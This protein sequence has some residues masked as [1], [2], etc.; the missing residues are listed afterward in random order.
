MDETVRNMLVA[1]R[2]FVRFKTARL[3][4]V[5]VEVRVEAA[6]PR[7]D[8][9]SYDHVAEASVGFPSGR[10]FVAGRTDWVGGSHISVEPGTYRVRMLCSVLD[11]LSG[12]GVA[13]HDAYA[14][15]MWPA[16]LSSARVIKRHLRP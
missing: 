7:L 4:V 11:T 3:A 15:E 9:D 8:L 14:V 16:S 6:E 5:P 12:D 1:G 2:G 10:L 13:G